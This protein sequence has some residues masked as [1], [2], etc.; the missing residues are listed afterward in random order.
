[1]SQRNVIN[2]PES[3]AV[4]VT[5]KVTDDLN[6]VMKILTPLGTCP[7]PEKIIRLGT[8]K[9]GVNRPLKIIYQ[10]EATLKDI[11]KTNK[12]NVNR[13]HNVFPDLT[14]AQR[15][16]NKRIRNEFNERVDNGEENLTLK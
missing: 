10:S 12:L 1:M 14:K 16:H 4:A 3:S 2:I 11:L 8:Y 5:Q 7:Q 13:D 6:Q 9:H 15:E